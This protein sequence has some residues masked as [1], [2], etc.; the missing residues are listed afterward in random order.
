MKTVETA[1]A[2][3][4]ADPMYPISSVSEFPPIT[5]RA[6]VMLALFLIVWL[7]LGGLLLMDLVSGLFR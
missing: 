3:I 5:I 7:L 6:R 1:T 2:D 4:S